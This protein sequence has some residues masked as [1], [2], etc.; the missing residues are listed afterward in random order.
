MLQDISA[1]ALA[2]TRM[3][4]HQC[5][6]RLAL[7][8]EVHAVLFTVLLQLLGDALLPL[9]R[10][11]VVLRKLHLVR[12]QRAGG[13]PQVVDVLAQLTV[14]GD[15]GGTAL[16]LHACPGANHQAQHKS[17]QPHVDQQLAGAALGTAGHFPAHPVPDHLHTASPGQPAAM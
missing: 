15:C 7:A 14:V 8:L 10:G 17:R 16:P 12:P 2:Q 9:H 13:G 3:V 11:S 5:R 4:G 1:S 6:Q